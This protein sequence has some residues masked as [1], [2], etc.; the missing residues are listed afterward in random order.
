MTI[1]IYNQNW[2]IV[3]THSIPDIKKGVLVIG[4]PSET[5]ITEV[6]EDRFVCLACQAQHFQAI[7]CSRSAKCVQEWSKIKVITHLGNVIAGG[8]G[9]IGPCPPSQHQ[10]PGVEY[11]HNRQC[12]FNLHTVYIQ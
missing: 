7:Y 4:T 9:G 10:L 1:Q 5:G 12:I 6:E 8:A 11:M 3:E 2:Y